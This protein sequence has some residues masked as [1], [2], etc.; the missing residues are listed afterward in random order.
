MGKAMTC[1]SA[2]STCMQTTR[3]ASQPFSDAWVTRDSFDSSLSVLRGEGQ[4]LDAG[5]LL[6]FDWFVV[7]LL[8]IVLCMVT[9][10]LVTRALVQVGSCDGIALLHVSFP[11][12]S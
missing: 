11:A 4:D 7:F 6:R 8:F 1:C 3:C 9:A 5:S 2:T 12:S 10:A